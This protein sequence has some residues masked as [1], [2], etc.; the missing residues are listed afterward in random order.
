M[1]RELG[2]W[3]RHL[4]GRRACQSTGLRGNAAAYSAGDGLWFPVS[5][6]RG[7]VLC[8]RRKRAQR[9]MSGPPC[10]CGHTERRASAALPGTTSR[11]LDGGLTPWGTTYLHL[12]SV[13]IALGSMRWPGSTAGLACPLRNCLQTI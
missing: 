10:S 5:H 13:C 6:P 11:G 1:Q 7:G 2:G 3:G 12:Y 9:R 8:T 4:A